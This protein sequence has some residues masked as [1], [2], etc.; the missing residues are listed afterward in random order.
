M[1]WSSGFVEID[2]VDLKEDPNDDCVLMV[3]TELKGPGSKFEI[4]CVYFTEKFFTNYFGIQWYQDYNKIQHQMVTRKDGLFVRWA[5]VKIEKFLDAGSVGPA[6]VFIT[7]QD[8]TWAEKVEM[9]KIFP[10]SKLSKPNT[11]LYFPLGK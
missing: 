6:K 7:E 5:L 8:L 10:A 1:S 11:Y 3:S 4:F 2:I 9:K